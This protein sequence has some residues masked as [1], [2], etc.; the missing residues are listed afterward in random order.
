MVLL[1]LERVMLVIGRKGALSAAARDS[2]GDREL[3]ASRPLKLATGV[4][5]Y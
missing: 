1:I 3:C 2:F 4:G 5:V